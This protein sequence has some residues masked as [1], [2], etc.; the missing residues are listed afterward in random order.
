MAL[1]VYGT[2]LVDGERVPFTLKDDDGPVCDLYVKH[3]KLREYGKLFLATPKLLEACEAVMH[4]C[5]GN[6][7]HEDKVRARDLVISAIAEA[8]SK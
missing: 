6:G 1:K 5:F 2:C 7:S 3:P 4:G 8:T